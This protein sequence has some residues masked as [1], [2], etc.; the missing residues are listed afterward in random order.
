MSY[1]DK[2]FFIGE[3]KNDMRNGFGIL[4]KSNGE[5]ILYN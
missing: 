3:F 2:S 5:S 1:K 4:T